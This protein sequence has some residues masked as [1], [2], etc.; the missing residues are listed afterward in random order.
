MAD[1]NYKVVPK[2]G[3]PQEVTLNGTKYCKWCYTIHAK[4]SLLVSGRTFGLD[5]DKEVDAKEDPDTKDTK[6]VEFGGHTIVYKSFS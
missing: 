3:N 4:G 6:Q 2:D 1:Y 5:F